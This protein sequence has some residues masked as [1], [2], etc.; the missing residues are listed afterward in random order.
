MAKWKAKVVKK[1]IINGLLTIGV[2]FD[3]GIEKF[4][5]NY[6]SKGGNLD[7]KS[8]VRNRI[9]ELESLATLDQG[10]NLGDVDLTLPITQPISE[11]QADKDR[12]EFLV[13]YEKW[14]HAKK[15]IDSGII[16]ANNPDIV[17]LLDKVKSQFKL[18]YLEVL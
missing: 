13:N 8:M 9:V 15:G 4:R 5:E 7:I 6:T 10:I 12:R 18:T 16:D 3:N 14:L 2:D 1:V 11:T 17:A